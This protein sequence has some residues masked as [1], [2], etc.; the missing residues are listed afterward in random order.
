MKLTT[1]FLLGT[2]SAFLVRTKLDEK[3]SKLTE[4]AQAFVEDAESIVFKHT[5]NAKDAVDEALQ[6]SGG[7]SAGDWFKSLKGSKAGRAWFDKRTRGDEIRSGPCGRM[8]KA[9]DQEHPRPPPPLHGPG[10]PE[11]HSHPPPP[12]HGPHGPDGPGEGPHPPPPHHGP[13]HGPPGEH[14][15][16]PPPGHHNPHDQRDKTLYQIL[17]E[18][19]YFTIL[20]DIVKSDKHI[21]AELNKTAANLTLFA[22]TD[23]ALE[24]FEKHKLPAEYLKKILL[25][26]TLPTVVPAG[27]VLRAKTL[28]TLY[29][30]DTI[31]QHQRL[32]V[33]I[34][35]RG[36]TL[37]YYARIIYV[38]VFANN[39]VLHAVDNLLF[40][41]PSILK[42]AELVPAGFSTFVNAAYKT[43]VV[44]TLNETVGA[45]VFAPS[46]RGFAKLGPAINAYLFSDR[47]KAT[48]T[49]LLKYHVVPNTLFYS[50]HVVQNDKEEADS[51]KRDEA[52]SRGLVQHY[53]FSTLVEN[54]K[55]LVDVLEWGRF[56]RIV[57]NGRI[58]GVSDIPAKNGVLSKI[59]NVILPYKRGMNMQVSD[60]SVEEFED[61][62]NDDEDE[63]MPT[64]EDLKDL[65]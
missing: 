37:N 49:K 56:K 43:G 15:H 9:L 8:R 11:Q 40:P 52:R 23:R 21:V 36:I 62:F 2:A 16:P 12:H 47:G 4:T 35:L 14:P 31:G 18:S 32:A 29:K 27:G 64:V 6:M 58:I 59:D 19:K 53:E 50:D 51:I 26:H 10:G 45:T 17:E 13:P 5:Q 33:D 63:D 28:E 38:D 60:M 25:Y 39:G 48:L 22:P 46:N 65:L 57:F 55:V 7:H 30:E 3:A 42:I 54:E 24:K 41:P 44:D 20:H 34:N 61:L 1:A